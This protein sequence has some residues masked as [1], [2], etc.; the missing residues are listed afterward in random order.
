M[1]RAVNTGRRERD[2][3]GPLLRVVG[4]R[5]EVGPWVAHL[6]RE[7]H[8]RGKEE[9]DRLPTDWPE[10]GTRRRA[11][12]GTEYVLRTRTL[13]IDP[14]DQRVTLELRAEKW[15]DGALLAAEERPLSERMYFRD[16]LVLLLERAG[17]DSVE[18]RAGY[19]GAEPTADDDF[20]VYIA[21]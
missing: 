18:V 6:G 8:R 11:D 12:D 3:I 19:T 14:L 13:A 5:F 15:R 17:F 16:E 21:S 10:D 9:R 20:L 4:E 7:E 2:F 1:C